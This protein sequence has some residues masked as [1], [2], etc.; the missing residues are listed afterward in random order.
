MIKINLWFIDA[1]HHHFKRLNPCKSNICK[2][3]SFKK[4]D[5]VLN[6]VPNLTHLDTLPHHK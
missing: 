3:F 4:P 2:G 1:P 5:F 6:F